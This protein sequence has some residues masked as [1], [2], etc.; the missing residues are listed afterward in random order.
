MIKLNLRDRIDKFKHPIGPKGLN[1]MQLQQE[2]EFRRCQTEREDREM[3]LKLQQEE[4][5]QGLQLKRGHS[6][7]DEE[8]R[9][10]IAQIQE[11]E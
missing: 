9:K 3:A 4:E 10:L 8:S 6:E 5:K 2:E 7:I 11:M 1:M